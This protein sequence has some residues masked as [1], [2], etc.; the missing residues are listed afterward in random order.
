MILVWLCQDF[1]WCWLLV[2]CMFPLL[3]LPMGLEFLIFPRLQLCR[4]V[5][6]CQMLSQHLIKGSWVFSFEFVYVMNYI[7]GFLYIEPPHHS[8]DKACLILV[9]DQFDVFLNSVGK[10]FM[11]YFCIDIHKENW[12][13]VFFLCWVFEWCTYQNNC[14]FIEWIG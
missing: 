12:S 6:F 13:K 3:C 7:D 11:E 14:D 10:Y 2:C 5:E 1:V 4:N 9:D 8:W